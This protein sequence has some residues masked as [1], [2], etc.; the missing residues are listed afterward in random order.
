MNDILLGQ[1]G[2]KEQ[3]FLRVQSKKF[4]YMGSGKGCHTYINNYPDPEENV[5]KCFLFMHQQLLIWIHKVLLFHDGPL[6]S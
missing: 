3:Y 5:K 2:F 4:V 6:Q 1:V